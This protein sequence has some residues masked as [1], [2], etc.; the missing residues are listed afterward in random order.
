MSAAGTYYA[1][2]P[3]RRLP[4]WACPVRQVNQSSLPAR[5][6]TLK[7]IPKKVAMKASSLISPFRTTT[8]GKC[9]LSALYVIACLDQLRVTSEHTPPSQPVKAIG[10]NRL[11]AITSERVPKAL[12]LPRTARFSRSKFSP[13]KLSE[14]PRARSA[15]FGCI[16]RMSRTKQSAETGLN[17]KVTVLAGQT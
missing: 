10:K 7:T 17:V 5:G 9:F 3:P 15:I 6:S 11:R 2:E 13:R 16:G 14:V 4:V 12:T 1:D 8:V